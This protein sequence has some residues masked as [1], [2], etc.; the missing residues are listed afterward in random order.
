MQDGDMGSRKLVVLTNDLEKLIIGQ[1]D[2]ILIFVGNA[3][4]L[5]NA[6]WS[7]YANMVNQ[8]DI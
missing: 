4:V 6:R 7:D 3:R 2:G 5:D 8:N 1:V